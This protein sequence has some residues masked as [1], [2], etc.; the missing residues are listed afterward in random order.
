M[1]FVV[2]AVGQRMP[3]WVDAGF[4]DYARRMPRESALGLVEI[5][6]QSRAE[7]GEDARG[8]ERVIEAE[9]KRISAALPND[10]Y[11]VA[12]DERGRAFT[13]AELARRIDGWKMDAHD[14]AFVIGGADGLTPRLKREADLMWSLSALTL[15][16]AL[17]RV[18][19]AE[20]LYRAV[21]ILRNHPYHR[22]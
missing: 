18:I 8:I 5:K 22:A 13:T 9:G 14:V 17:V 3:A 19:V 7:K 20:Q 15:P 11:T 6:P 10:A 16:H 12:L 1:R 4:D 2:V 21:S